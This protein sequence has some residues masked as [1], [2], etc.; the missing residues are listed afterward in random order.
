MPATCG[1]PRRTRVP[2]GQ[3]SGV[4]L[5]CLHLLM[6]VLQE[7]FDVGLRSDQ[8]RFNATLRRAPLAQVEQ[9][10]SAPLYLGELDNSVSFLADIADH[11]NPPSFAGSPPAPPVYQTSGNASHNYFADN[12]L[13]QSATLEQEHPSGARGETPIMSDDDH[14]DLQVIHDLHQ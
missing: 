1:A 6:N 2:A 12:G 13:S 7:V 3:A 9:S 14:T 4:A 5:R 8:R 10:H 11:V